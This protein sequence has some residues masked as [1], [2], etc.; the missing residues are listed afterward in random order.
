MNSKQNKAK[1][2]KYAGSVCMTRNISIS[3]LLL[4][5]QFS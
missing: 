4:R 5:G 2:K 1:N 3:Q